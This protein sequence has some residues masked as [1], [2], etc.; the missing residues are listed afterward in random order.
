MASAFGDLFASLGERLDEDLLPAL[1]A[2]ASVPTADVRSWLRENGIAHVDPAA[3]TVATAAELDEAARRV[4]SQTRDR[5]TVLGVASGLVGAVAVPP[6]VLASVVQT[7]RLAQ[8]LAVL[9]GFD[10]ETDAGKVVLWRAI[11][12]AYEVEL[13]QQGPVGLKVRELPDLVRAQLP[14]T[15]QATAWLTRQVVVRTIASVAGRVTRLIPGLGA[16]LAGYGARKRIAE[17]GERMIAV[18][19]RASEGVPF[20]LEGETDAVEVP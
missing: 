6:E 18:L 20:E 7:L 9:Y 3:G 17:Q 12:A 8:R 1:Y 2:A 5:A 14:A 10:P 19:A 11:A 4:V 15:Q 13:P 16:G